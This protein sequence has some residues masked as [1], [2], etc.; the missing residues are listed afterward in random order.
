MFSP[1]GAAAFASTRT[2]NPSF[3]ARTP[4]SV[5]A[6]VGCPRPLIRAAAPRQRTSA[7]LTPQDGRL[8]H[9]EAVHPTGVS[10]QVVR[11]RKR[12]EDGS[13]RLRGRSGDVHDVRRIVASG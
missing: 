5:R 9:T 1:P 12:R 2:P 10:G 8:S 11:T 13:R 3:G 4:P 6:A 7:G